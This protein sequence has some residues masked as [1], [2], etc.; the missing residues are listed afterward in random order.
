[1][2]TT[3]RV[4]RQIVSGAKFKFSNK[5]PRQ[6]SYEF[7]LSDLPKLARNAFIYFGAFNVYGF[8]QSK[9][10]RPKD[11]K[12]LY[13]SQDFPKVLLSP[14]GSYDPRNVFWTSSYCLIFG[15]LLQKEKGLKAVNV[16]FAV[17]Y[18]AAVGGLWILG[19]NKAY[20]EMRFNVPGLKRDCITDKAAMGADCIASAA[21]YTFCLTQGFRGRT[22]FYIWAVLDLATYGPYILPA[23][24]TAAAAS[25]MIF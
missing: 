4:K 20:N 8:W 12:T 17:S 22:A 2:F 3:G 10:M 1:M 19:A 23:L 9:Q 14:A 6:E 24:A 15:Y 16:L 13:A 25:V 5:T 7:A 21:L 18:L 11:Y